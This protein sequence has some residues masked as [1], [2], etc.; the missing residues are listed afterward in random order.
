[1]P[2]DATISPIITN[3]S[4]RIWPEPDA[5]LRSVV[6]YAVSGIGLL[7]VMI[8]LWGVGVGLAQLVRVERARLAGR[9]HRA[10]SAHLRHVLGFYML[11][12]LS[13]LVASDIL[14]TLVLPTLQHLAVLG[15]VMALRVVA[16]ITLAHELRE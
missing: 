7:S 2:P 1:M 13:F 6:E 12:T 15:G 10:E 14:E 11:L 16:G 9:D 5:I 8:A 3:S 4:H